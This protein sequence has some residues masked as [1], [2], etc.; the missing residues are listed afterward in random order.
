MDIILHTLSK[1][2]SSY[3]GAPSQ[4]GD[5]RIYS[6]KL[7]NIL[8]MPKDSYILVKAGEKELIYNPKFYDA[9]CIFRSIVGNLKK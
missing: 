2:L 6:G 3:L 1:T 5:I 8:V 9:E 7:G 4:Y